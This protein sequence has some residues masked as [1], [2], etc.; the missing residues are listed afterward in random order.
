[1]VC[2]AMARSSPATFFAS[3]FS[4]SPSRIMAEVPSDSTKVP[5]S[6]GGSARSL[7][8]GGSAGAALAGGGC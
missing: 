8:G 2:L 5:K 6:T 7:R 1:M 4:G 3:A